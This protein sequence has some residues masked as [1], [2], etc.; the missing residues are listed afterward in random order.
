MGVIEGVG[1]GN[2]LGCDP[3]DVEC[4]PPTAAALLSFHCPL[5]AW[6][7]EACLID[8]DSGYVLLGLWSGAERARRVV[9]EVEGEEEGGWKGGIAR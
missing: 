8:G 1:L 5:L 3:G 4:R 9:A 7:I 2:D 6:L